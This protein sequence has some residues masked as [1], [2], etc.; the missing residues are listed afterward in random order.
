MKIYLID[1]YDSFTYN[2]VHLLREVGVADVAV[3]RNDVVDVAEVLA[4]DAL[5]VSPGPG[6]P[7]DAGKLMGVLEAVVGK[8][9]VMGVCLGLQAIGEHFGG[10]LRNLNDVYHG[11]ATPIEVLE[12]KGLFEGLGNEIE[13]GRYHSWVLDKET[14]PAELVLTARD[15]EGEVMALR[16]R[17]L[18][19][20]A[21]Q[22]HPES[23]LTPS[24]AQLMSNFIDLVRT[25]A[26]KTTAS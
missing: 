17:S 5:L 9:P 11:V 18:P 23:I 12:E 1:N 14:V 24:G 4:S 6:V 13:V 25:E 10:Q 20:H 21:L 7:K 19:I 26:S 22:F 2:L 3:H 8:M 15:S 16:H